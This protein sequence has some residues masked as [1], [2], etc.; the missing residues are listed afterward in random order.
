MS[1]VQYLRDCTAVK[2][3]QLDLRVHAD[4]LIDEDLEEAI[5]EMV[6]TIGDK[7]LRITMPVNDGFRFVCNDTGQPIEQVTDVALEVTSSTVAMSG[8]LE[9]DIWIRSQEIDIQQV[10]ADLHPLQPYIGLNANGEMV[11]L[12]MHRDFE[13][14]RSTASVEVVYAADEEEAKKWLESLGEILGAKVTYG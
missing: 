2:A 10:F 12:G 14:A 6:Q 3:Q 9:G 5:F 13:G 4:F 11:D 1:K 8:K 7:G